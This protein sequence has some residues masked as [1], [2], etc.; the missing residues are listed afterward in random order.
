MQTLQPLCDYPAGSRVVIKNL[1]ECPKKRIRL[2]AMGL[3]PG[4][5]VEVED[6]SYGPCR[7]R[8]R[9][10]SL[11][12]GKGIAANILCCPEEAHEQ[13]VPCV[14][15]NGRSCSPHINWFLKK[16]LRSRA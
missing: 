8:V 13:C 5:V 4:T 12:L 1:S 7:I 3:T 11:V 9:D 10:T 2:C 16:L 6:V 14:L 15:A